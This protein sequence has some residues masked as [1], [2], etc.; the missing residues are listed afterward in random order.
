MIMIASYITMVGGWGI[1]TTQSWFAFFFPFCS[2]SIDW[3]IAFPLQPSNRIT[4]APLVQS[5]QYVG[6][7]TNGRHASVNPSFSQRPFWREK[8]INGA[9]P[10]KGDRYLDTGWIHPAKTKI[11]K[12]FWNVFFEL[13]GFWSPICSRKFPLKYSKYSLTGWHHHIDGCW[14]KMGFSQSLP[15]NSLGIK[16]HQFHMIQATATIFFWKR[17]WVGILTWSFNK[18]HPSEATNKTTSYISLWLF[19]KKELHGTPMCHTI[20]I[21]AYKNSPKSSPEVS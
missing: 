7:Q 5:C 10:L 4:E 15:L 14:L 11:L 1:F 17:R 8:S 18:N 12:C 3:E 2:P 19:N 13:L 21:L 16:G 9:K 20:A 6:Y